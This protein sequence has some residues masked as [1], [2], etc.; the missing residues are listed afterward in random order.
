MCLIHQPLCLLPCRYSS[1]NNCGAKLAATQNWLKNEKIEMLIGCISEL[2]EE[3]EQTM[4]KSGVNDFSIMYS[5]RKNCAQ[6]WLG[7]FS[8]I[9]R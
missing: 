5:C 8:M 1:E 6:L 3:E 4:L 2:S 9:I 7:R